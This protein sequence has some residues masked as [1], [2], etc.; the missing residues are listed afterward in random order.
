MIR[1]VNS[2]GRKAIRAAHTAVTLE[3]FKKG[4]QQGRWCFDLKLDLARYGFPEDASIRVEA[5]RGNAF[6]RWDWG[7]VGVP[8][9]LTPA[10]RVLEDVPET[11]QFRVSV[12]AGGH[13][14]LLLGLADRLR[15]RLPTE[16]LLPL[17]A[18]DLGSEVWR[19]DYGQGDDVVTLQ[20]NREI[21]DFSDAVRTDPAF[22]ALVM[23]Q[24][25][26]SVLERALLVDREDS[27]DPEGRWRRWFELAHRLLPPGVRIPEV[28]PDAADEDLA[29]ADE[30]IA[31]V[32]AAFAAKRV[33]ALQG[34]RQ[35]WRG[36]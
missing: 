33:K 18:A 15:P 27:A 4:A 35:V 5:W 6:Q 30:W 34:Y 19:L 25:L 16:S 10:A 32:V 9:V 12:V 2:T 28:G 17:V 13:S 7:T 29:R 21:P 3:R 22:R 31:S 8:A 14:G 1:R 20:V 36:K 11:C 24:V 23:P 26:R